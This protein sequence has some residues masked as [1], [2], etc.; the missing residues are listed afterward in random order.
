MLRSISILIAPIKSNRAMIDDFT[1]LTNN[2]L[3]VVCLCFGQNKI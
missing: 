2:P 3:E 1:I